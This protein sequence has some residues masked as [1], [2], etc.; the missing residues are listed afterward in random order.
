MYYIVCPS[1]ILYFPYWI[2]VS[3]SFFE[4]HCQ[5]IMEFPPSHVSFTRQWANIFFRFSWRNF[6]YQ[7]KTTSTSVVHW[8]D[9]QHMFFGIVII[10]VVVFH[11]KV[12]PFPLFCNRAIDLNTR[13]DKCLKW[14][15]FA[16]GASVVFLMIR[17]VY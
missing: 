4:V 16:W 2:V 12:L 6:K 5:L 11:F 1:R 10:I 17:V 7:C 14:L 3:G 13:E 9:I 8:M 15:P